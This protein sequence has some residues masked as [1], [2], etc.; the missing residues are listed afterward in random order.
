MEKNSYIHLDKTKNNL[1]SI[2]SRLFDFDFGEGSENEGFPSVDKVPLD[3]L[4]N[5][6]DQGS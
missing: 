6:F 1:E 5:L 3:I 2:E 4:L